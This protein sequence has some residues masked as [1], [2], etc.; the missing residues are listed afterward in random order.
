[1]KIPRGPIKAGDCSPPAPTGKWEIADKDLLAAVGLFVLAWSSLESAIEAGIYKQTGLTPLDSSIITAGLGFKSRSL[2]LSSLLNRNSEKN[3][4]AIA[5]IKKMQ[6]VSD[7][8]DILHGVTGG[9]KHGI[10][11]NRRKTN[12]KFTSKFENYDTKRLLTLSLQCN[13]LAENLLKE[14]KISKNEYVHFHQEVH[15][16]ANNL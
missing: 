5:I 1:M 4:R 3:A 10:W 6:K 15:N 2:I 13:K 7:R 8:N 16:K 9:A 12:F 11:F 14:L